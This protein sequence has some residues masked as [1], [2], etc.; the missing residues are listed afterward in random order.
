[1]SEEGLTKTYN[2]KIFI[3]RQI[4]IDSNKVDQH[5]QML[6]R[7]VDIEAVDLIESLMR[8]FVPTY[9]RPEDAN[10][11]EKSDEVAVCN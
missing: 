1:M 6:K 10:G 8:E 5:L 3:G 11:K 9:I 4:D 2:E 7:V